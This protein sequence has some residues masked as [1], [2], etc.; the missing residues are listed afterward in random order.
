[1][2]GAA[3]PA[4]PFLV[5]LAS[6]SPALAVIEEFD[7]RRIAT[8]LELSEARFSLTTHLRV[9]NASEPVAG[10]CRPILTCNQ[11]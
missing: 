3:I 6:A 2:R 5:R 10:L 7:D 1:M 8:R 9:G 4:L 11:R